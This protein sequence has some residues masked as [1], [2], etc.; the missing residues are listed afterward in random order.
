[1]NDAQPAS[2]HDVAY[3][4]RFSSLFNRGHGYSF[5]CDARG[6]ISFRSLSAPER[7]SYLQVLR[8]V[9]SELS[10]PVVA[11]VRDRLERAAS[12]SDAG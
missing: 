8:S 4:L 7:S 10:P 1:M 11:M 2:H 9:G 3:E 5:P 12:G 6:A